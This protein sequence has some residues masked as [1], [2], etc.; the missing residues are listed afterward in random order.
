MERIFGQK[1]GMTSL[2]N[3]KGEQVGVTLIEVFLTRVL[4]IKTEARDGYNALVLGFGA[5][6]EKHVRS[7]Q[8]GLFKKVNC[9]PVK[10][11]RETSADDC[12]K[13]QVG[14]ELGLKD[15]GE[16]KQ[17]HVRAVSKGRGFAGTIKRHHFQ[18]GRETHG[19]K[20][21]REPGSIGQHSYPAKVFKGRR[22]AG[23]QGDALT[24]VRNMEV[25]QCVPD[26]N[27]LVVKGSVPGAKN[28]LVCIT[29]INGRK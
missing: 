19:N 18:R 21:H 12:A 22:M 25:V 14:Q 4:Q 6:R 5:R 15:F 3:D 10:H 16:V 13:F 17:V 23:H 29:K 2:F 1:I 26:K 9:P 8:K 11:I 27:L 24:T 28:N 7:P 20:N